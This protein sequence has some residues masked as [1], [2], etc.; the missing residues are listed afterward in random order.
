MAGGAADHV[1]V[2][3]VTHAKV[4]WKDLC[5]MSIVSLDGTCQTFR[6]LQVLALPF[7]IPELSFFR[8]GRFLTSFG[9][10]P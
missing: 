7:S 8:N 6:R 3:D 10:L 5:A 9:R 2:H 4:R 1:C